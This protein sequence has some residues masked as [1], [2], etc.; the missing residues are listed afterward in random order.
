MDVA[1]DTPAIRATEVVKGQPVRLHYLDW[2]RVI[3]IFG[4]FLYHASRPF[5]MQEWLIM[6]H[7]QSVVISFVFLI[8]LG[9]W[10]MPMFFMI[11]GVGS[12]F[13]L[14]RRSGKQF[15]NER[16]RRLF[17]P[18]IAGCILFSPVQ[19]YME[20]LHKG[21]YEGSFIDFLPL[22]LKDWWQTLTSTFSPS[23][24]ETLGSH[25]WFLGF[26]LAFSLVSLPLFIW[27]KGR[28]GRRV[29]GC[30]GNVAEK[31]GGLFIFLV[32]VAAA[33]ILLQGRFPGYADW[34]DFGYL[35][36]FFIY[37]Y[38]VFSDERFVQAIQRD[39]KL[40]L[41]A[42]VL[43]TLFMVVTLVVTGSLESL[44][45]PDAVIF[46]VGWGLAS[47]NGWCWTIAVLYLGMRILKSRNRWLDYG[48][49][50]IVPFFLIH[51]P[52]IVLI[53]FY[54][55]QWQQPILVKWPVIVVTSFLTSLVL[56]E[57]L[58]R[59]IPPARTFFGM[60]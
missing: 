7:E 13:A 17:I 14:R 3:A 34:A 30:L 16:L 6:D 24:F 55:V 50:A 27:F 37:G 2:L 15:V 57:L 25:L 60:K 33:R 29:I 49:E 41:L 26:L 51:Q 4:V 56:Y 9:S 22:L 19:F 59:R 28:N 32:P 54:L 11:S 45:S 47:I 35:L 53:A 18:F 1:S 31:R 40:F 38:I 5:I 21:W 10:G 20:W 12:H 36:V 42:G 44:N 39:G 23:L 52:V 8:F 58:I 46:Y 48:Q 43:S